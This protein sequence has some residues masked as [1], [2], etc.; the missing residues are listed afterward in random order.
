M[1]TTRKKAARRKKPARG[2]ASA[3]IRNRQRPGDGKAVE[4]ITDTAREVYEKVLKLQKPRLT[5]PLRSLSNVKYDSRKG[6]F[7]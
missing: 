2:P 4:R 6:F 7:E 3:G 1:S 5:F